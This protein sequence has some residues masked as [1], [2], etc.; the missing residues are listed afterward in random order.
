[1]LSERGLALCRCPQ[2]RPAESA[3]PGRPV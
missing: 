3:R 2:G 1:L